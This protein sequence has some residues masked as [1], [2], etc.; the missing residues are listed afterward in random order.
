MAGFFS[1]IG[2]F[3]LL[4]L[5][6]DLYF[7]TLYGVYNLVY[8]EPFWAVLREVNISTVLYAI[9]NGFYEEIFSSVFAWRL[10]LN[11]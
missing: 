1:G 8:P 7:E 2:L 5:A 11:I 10:N 3:I 6:M 9:L 4:S